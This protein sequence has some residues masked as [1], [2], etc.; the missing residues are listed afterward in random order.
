MIPSHKGFI[1]KRKD[2]SEIVNYDDE[3]FP[4]YIYDGYIF[5]GCTWERVPHYHD[6]VEFISIYSGE[7][8][9]SVNGMNITLK[10]GDTLFVNADAIHYSFSTNKYVTRYY[11]AV[12]HP[13]II[14]SSFAVEKKA[15]RPILSDKEVPYVHFQNGEHDA[16]AVQTLLKDMHL[17]AKG[18]EFLI[19]KYFFELWDI[20]SHRFTDNYRVL[21]K[22]KDEDDSHNKA[23]KTMMLFID[24]NYNKG[25]NLKDIA[26]SGG[27]SQTLCNQIFNK[28]TD[29]SPIEYLMHYRSR[30]AADLLQTGSMSMSEIAETAGFSGA[31]YMAEV[32]KKYYNMSPRDYRKSL[33]AKQRK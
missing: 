32:F 4:S 5:S 18:N 14:C 15:I 33:I 22:R 25:I 3:S 28:L 27:V 8:G 9:Y 7:M 12:L 19:T 2:G 6:D 20:L 30:K 24:E 11:L 1:I 16:Q 21:I 31:S 17:N 29:K 26:E 13:S 23:L 10:K